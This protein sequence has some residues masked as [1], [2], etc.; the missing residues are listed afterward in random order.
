MNETQIKALLSSLESQRN[1]A[2]NGLAN[3]QAD[4]AVANAKIEELNAALVEARKSS[5]QMAAE[6]AEKATVAA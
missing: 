1:A 5:E 6:S 4:L 2:L 3:T